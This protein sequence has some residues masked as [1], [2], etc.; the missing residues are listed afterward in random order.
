MSLRVVK[1]PFPAA[2]QDGGRFGW[3]MYGVPRS[4]AFD[5]L[6]MANANRLLGNPD[7]A[8]GLELTLLGGLFEAVGDVEV[9]VAGAPS[10]V[11][12]DGCAFGVCSRARGIGAVLRA[13]QTLEIGPAQSGLRVYLCLRGGISGKPVLGSVSG[14][15][16][17]AGDVLA[18]GFAEECGGREPLPETDNDAPIPIMPG[19]HATDFDLQT[20]T[21]SAYTVSPHSNRVGIRLE[22]ASLTP[23]PDRPSEPAC[24][25]AV[26]VANNGQPIVL[27]P[28]GPTIG[29]Y[30]IV[31]VVRR[32]GLD[33]L[34]QLRPGDAVRFALS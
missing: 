13:G 8:P 9:A 19:P 28:D 11:A 30:P 34:G 7:D 33:R 20:L 17:G 25:G 21:E 31:A 16:V 1:L 32:A 24:I 3:L 2:L 5:R 22:G 27:G 4:G 29:G 18:R 14:A 26:Q 10:A 12:V 6:S 15:G 23:Q